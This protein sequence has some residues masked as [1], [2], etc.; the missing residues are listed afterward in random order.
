MSQGEIMGFNIGNGSKLNSSKQNPR[1]A[2]C[3]GVMLSDCKNDRYAARA[4]K[5]ARARQLRNNLKDG[6]IS[7]CSV[8]ASPS[9]ARSANIGQQMYFKMRPRDT[10]HFAEL[11]GRQF[12][13][14]WEWTQAHVYAFASH[15]H[16]TTK[17][18][19]LRSMKKLTNVKS[20]SSLFCVFKN[21]IISYN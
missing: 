12:R 11:L 5:S 19:E 14:I 4:R 9:D 20:D 7:K 1:Q 8:S 2:S 17:G 21:A 16:L 13:T 10:E 6:S 15:K 18:R 3:V